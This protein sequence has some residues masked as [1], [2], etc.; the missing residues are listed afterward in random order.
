MK[1]DIQVR[2]STAKANKMLG[3]IRKSFKFLDIHNTT[4][5]Y[6]SL[7]RPHLEYAI[8]SWYPYC[9]KDINELEK[10]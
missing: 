3:L 2:H 1:W 10:V 6:K 9:V 8:S 4:L 7:V 5:L